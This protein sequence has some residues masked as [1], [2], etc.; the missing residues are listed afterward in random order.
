MDLKYPGGCAV[1]SRHLPATA[2]LF[3][4]TPLVILRAITLNGLIGVALGYLY[5]RHGLDAAML[6]HFTADIV[7][8]VL[9]TL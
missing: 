8:H 4:I 6:S 2:A 5:F 1:R 3:P 9:L 7:L